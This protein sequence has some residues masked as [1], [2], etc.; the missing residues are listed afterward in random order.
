MKLGKKEWRGEISTASWRTSTNMGYVRRNAQSD[1]AWQ[2][3]ASSASSCPNTKL[4]QRNNIDTSRQSERYQNQPR[5]VSIGEAPLAQTQPKRAVAIKF[6]AK[7]CGADTESR[8]KM[9]NCMEKRASRAGLPSTR[10]WLTQ[11]SKL[12]STTQKENEMRR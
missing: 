8:R 11:K 10:K 2:K 7:R 6:I 5:G 1:S 3:R 4:K 9:S 12:N